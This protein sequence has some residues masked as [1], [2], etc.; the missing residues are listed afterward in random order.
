[1]TTIEKMKITG[2]RSF[3]PSEAQVIQFEKPLTIIVGH[4]GAGKT[5]IIEALNYATTGEKPPGTGTGAAFVHDP[6][7]AGQREVK[8]S[9]KLLFCTPNNSKVVVTR[10]LQLEQGKEKQTLK[11]LDS[12]IE[13]TKANGVKVS[14]S[15][16]CSEIDK[17]VPMLMGVSPAILQSVIF[18]HQEESNWPLTGTDAE[19]KKRFDLIF[20]ADRYRKGLVELKERQKA[21]TAQIKVLEPELQVIQARRDAIEANQQSLE[22]AVMQVAEA[23][24][25]MTT[26]EEQKSAIA[27]RFGKNAELAK[28]VKTLQTD[29]VKANAVRREVAAKCEAYRLEL[30]RELSDTDAE[31]A[32]KQRGFDAAQKKLREALAG[33]QQALAAAEAAHAAAEGQL[34]AT[35]AETS[36]LNGKLSALQDDM[37][38]RE[39]ARKQMAKKWNFDPANPEAA[40][41]VLKK[42]EVQLGAA[43]ESFGTGR[44][45]LDAKVAD[46]TA[47]VAVVQ[48]ER[49]NLSKSEATTKQEIKGVE[50]EIEAKRALGG[51][52]AAVEK[53]LEAARKELAAA[54]A[55]VGDVIAFEASIEELQKAKNETEKALAA[56]SEALLKAGQGNAAL[57]RAKMVQK[58]VAAKEEELRALESK[59]KALLT[60]L[61]RRDALPAFEALPKSVTEALA[62]FR[63]EVTTLQRLLD[64]ANARRVAANSRV[65]SLTAEKAALDAAIKVSRAQLTALDLPEGIAEQLRAVEET[66]EADA[67]RVG[68]LSAEHAMYGKFVEHAAAKGEC[69]VCSRGFAKKA[70]AAQFEQSLH[71]KLKHAEESLG[72]AQK[73]KL[74]SEQAV[75]VLRPAVPI[76]IEL[77]R[78][79]AQQ[80]A[81]AAELAAKLPQLQE[82]TSE[83]DNVRTQLKES[84]KDLAAFEPL[85]SR[86]DQLASVAQQLERLRGDAA[87]HEAE[88]KKLGATRSLDELQAEMAKLQK[89]NASAASTLAEKRKLLETARKSIASKEKTVAE[90]MEKLVACDSSA[91]STAVLQERLAQLNLALSS[92]A[93]LKGAA[94]ANLKRA[95]ADRDKAAD[96]LQ[97]YVATQGSLIDAQEKEISS[98]RAELSLSSGSNKDDVASVKAQLQELGSVKLAHEA[99]VKESVDALRACKSNLESTSKK[100][101]DA[102][103]DRK[104]LDSNVKYRGARSELL[105][106]EEQIRAKREELAGLGSLE[107]LAQV[108][109]DQK[110]L[111]AVTSKV[112][113][114][115]GHRDTIKAQKQDYESKIKRAEPAKVHSDL[116]EKM[117]DLEAT[118]VGKLFF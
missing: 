44:K 108:E 52:K 38:K 85:L 26:L 104:N 11:T 3:S 62:S 115:R 110:E 29:I 47:A 95:Q 25:K 96:D 49:S 19:L 61:L 80:T 79:M 20:S 2:I 90:V 103:L 99:K 27:Q 88:C 31:L 12:T 4:N 10:N 40:G 89:Q 87:A 22:A 92:S 58:Q 70:E 32:E 77:K 72:P 43:K 8:A 33:Q 46:S 102:A 54:H 42:M 118:K 57:E 113:R 15:S 7:H 68:E 16:K 107:V 39:A 117:I 63:G 6:K 51:A 50:R 75:A 81:V 114:L 97:M 71:A 66:M 17:Q 84:Q 106:H 53:Q 48:S 101:N 116:I 73:D 35:L 14:Q 74:E 30:D 45:E 69:L 109:K 5:T 9:V 78:L 91:E 41:R 100:I 65:D 67:A 36:N 21:M 93:A 23:D 83:A 105:Q 98:F 24:E 76:E 94:D 59:S 112:E 37:D 18:C 13:I 34:K 60:K 111:E 55:S 56:S 86:A 82:E 64:E 28:R 1:M